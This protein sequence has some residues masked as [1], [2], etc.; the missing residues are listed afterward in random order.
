MAAGEHVPADEL[1]V[2]AAVLLE[3][4]STLLDG[5]RKALREGHRDEWA[6]ARLAAYEWEARGLADDPL[7]M[8][9]AAPGMLPDLLARRAATSPAD[10]ATI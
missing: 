2:A 8:Y 4:W 10:P 5:V 6:L 1:R 9:A 3:A 7:G